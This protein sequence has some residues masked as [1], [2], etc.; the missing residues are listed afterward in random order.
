MYVD[1]FYTTD[2]TG[3]SLE[4]SLRISPIYK[5]PFATRLEVANC[6]RMCQLLPNYYDSAHGIVNTWYREHMVS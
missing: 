2:E 6:H 5:L 3:S 1:Y 4:T